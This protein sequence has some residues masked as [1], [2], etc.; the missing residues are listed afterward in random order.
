MIFQF[1]FVLLFIICHGFYSCQRQNIIIEKFDIANKNEILTDNHHYITEE[2]LIKNWINNIEN[3]QIIDS[4]V[5][6]NLLH[7]YK[8]VDSYFIS[9]YKYSPKVN[10]DSY[11]Y[12]KKL[13]ELEMVDAFILGYEFRKGRF[14]KVKRN[15]NIDI[16]QFT[17]FACNF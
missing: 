3:E 2:Y 12:S 5:C 16:T 14:N 15:L 11:K 10:F 7:D 4:F 1:K 8:S 17:K 6:S 13:C 9:F